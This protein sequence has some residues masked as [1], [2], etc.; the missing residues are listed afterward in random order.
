[1]SSRFEG[2]LSQ[3]IT[4]VMTCDNREDASLIVN[5]AFVLGAVSDVAEA[6]EEEIN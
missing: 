2:R 4:A 6:V 1:M 5:E 3:L